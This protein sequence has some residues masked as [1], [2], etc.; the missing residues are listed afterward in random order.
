METSNA[1]LSTSHTDSRNAKDIMG[2]VLVSLIITVTLK[3]LCL[4]KNGLHIT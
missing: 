1:L 3:V 2:W 4:T